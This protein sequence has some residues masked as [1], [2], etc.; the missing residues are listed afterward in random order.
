[1]DTDGD[2]PLW[3]RDDQL[4]EYLC[5]SL[6]RAFGIGRLP[7]DGWGVYRLLDKAMIDGS[8]YVVAAQIK[9]MWKLLK[10][11]K[12]LLVT[13]KRI[14]CLKDKLRRQQSFIQRYDP[15]NDAFSSIVWRSKASANMQKTF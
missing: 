5:K 2:G 14:G 12:D 1:M 3:E 7:R 15:G 11:R 8:L 6:S 13:G 9:R 10:I 4:H